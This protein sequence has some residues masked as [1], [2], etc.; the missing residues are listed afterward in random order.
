MDIKNRYIN[1]YIKK[2][3]KKKGKE[4]QNGKYEK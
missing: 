3:K 2:I 4:E 1:R